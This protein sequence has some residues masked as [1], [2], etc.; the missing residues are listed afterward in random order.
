M[1]FFVVVVVF[2]IYSA[3][4]LHNTYSVSK[5]NLVSIKI[6]TLSEINKEIISSSLSEVIGDDG[7]PFHVVIGKHLPVIRGE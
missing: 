5:V 2:I 4:V 3:A 6:I 1:I 7:V